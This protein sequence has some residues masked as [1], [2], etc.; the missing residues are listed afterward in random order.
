MQKQARR[1]CSEGSGEGWS[2]SGGK[3]GADGGRDAAWEEVGKKREVVR[4]RKEW[5][6][7][8]Q[9][10]LVLQGRLRLG[11]TAFYH[12]G[13]LIKLSNWQVDEIQV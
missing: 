7:G 8:P 6:P 11:N 9:S 3:R 1:C 2:G 5:D 10:L 12:T 13:L 4:R